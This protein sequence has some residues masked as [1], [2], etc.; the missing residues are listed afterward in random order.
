VGGVIAFDVAPSGRVAALGSDGF[1]LS[2]DCEGETRELDL[3]FAALRCRFRGEDLVVLGRGSE[4][5]S[6]A[7]DGAKRG[8]ARV[9][10]DARDVAVLPGGSILVGYGRRGADRHGVLLERF[11]DAPSVFAD[12][13][14]LDLTC[15]AT[16]SG[17]VWVLGTA[18][19]PPTCRAE[20]LRPAAKGFTRK[21]VV[22]LPAPPRAAAIGPDGALYVLLEPGESLVRVDLGAAG[23]VIRVGTPLHGLARHGKRLLGCGAKGV[24]DLSGLLPRPPAERHP[25]ALPPC[26]P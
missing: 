22:A 18:Q 3:D 20:R 16:E 10:E 1:T 2:L 15:L 17:G 5:L 6:L 23:A 12:P 24:E 7:G 21:E 8:Q 25:P 19:E 13:G 9:R 11:G 26:S 14:M 4:L